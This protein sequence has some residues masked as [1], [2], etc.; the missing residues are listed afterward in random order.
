MALSLSVAASLS[1]LRMISSLLVVDREAFGTEILVPPLPLPLRPP[2]RNVLRFGID[3]ADMISRCVS[4]FVLASYKA[5]AYGAK[6]PGTWSVSALKAKARLRG[7]EVAESELKVITPECS[8][9][10]ESSPIVSG[11]RPSTTPFEATMV[12]VVDS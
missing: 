4:R 8:L 2:L 7:H 10:H 11:K 12:S 3:G 1:V 5:P 6:D 9:L